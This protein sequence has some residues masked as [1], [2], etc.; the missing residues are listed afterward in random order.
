[1][2]FVIGEFLQQDWGSPTHILN[3]VWTQAQKSV[4]SIHKAFSEF[5]LQGDI[6]F[7]RHKGVKDTFIVLSKTTPK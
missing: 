4:P 6:H 5:W 7:S 1:M 2:L 3:Q